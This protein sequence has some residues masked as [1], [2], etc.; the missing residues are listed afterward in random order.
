MVFILI[1]RNIKLHSKNKYKDNNFYFITLL[2]YSK[3]LI[4]LNNKKI[5]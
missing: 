5:L 4:I 1:I 3:I 2:I